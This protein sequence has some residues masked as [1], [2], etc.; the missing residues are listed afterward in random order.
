MDGKISKTNTCESCGMPLDEKTVSRFDM[1]YCIYCQNQESGTLSSYELVRSGCIGAA[2]KFFHKSDEEAIK[3][4]E[5]MLPKL[6][7]WQEVKK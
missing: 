6:P 1:H 2:K 4:V 3:M 5:E 7:R